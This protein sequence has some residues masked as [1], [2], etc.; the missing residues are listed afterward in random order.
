MKKVLLIVISFFLLVLNVNAAGVDK[1]EVYGAEEKRVGEEGVLNFNIYFSEL[2]KHSTK[3]IFAI[4]TVISTND[5]AIKITGMDSSNFDSVVGYDKDTKMYYIVSEVIPGASY[6]DYC[7]GGKLFC[8]DF[9]SRIKYVVKDTSVTNASIEIVAVQI[10]MLDMQEDREYTLDD[11]EILEGAVQKKHTIKIKKESSQKTDTNKKT[12]T[13]IST[14]PSK[15]ENKF[16]K[17]LEVE[18]YPIEFDRQ[19]MDYTITVDDEVNKLNIKAVPEDKNATYKVIGADDL[20]ASKNIVR[21]EVTAQD[22]TKQTYY[23]RIKYAE[24][25]NKPEQSSDINMEKEEKEKATQP[26][27]LKWIGIGVGVFVLLVIV[28]FVISK[29]K[30]RA[31]DKKLD[32]LDED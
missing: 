8:S 20:I 19:K 27:L 31:I 12:N 29:I 15:S 18:G 21:V 3:G 7:A 5:D 10:Y 14:T 28:I 6:G 26:N 1:V 13:N 17:S 32:S 24:K 30:D 9:K 16:L 4:A 2:E 23:I 25:E 11:A 22:K